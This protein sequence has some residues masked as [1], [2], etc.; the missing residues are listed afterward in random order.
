LQV[1]LVVGVPDPVDFVE[2]ASI[3]DEIAH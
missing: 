1:V 3:V 2:P